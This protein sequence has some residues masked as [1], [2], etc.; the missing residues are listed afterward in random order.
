MAFWRLS[1]RES[2]TGQID[3]TENR[4]IKRWY[5]TWLP[6]LLERQQGRQ[7]GQLWDRLYLGLERL[8]GLPSDLPQE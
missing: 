7:W 1:V 2:D 3:K 5:L 8:L 6:L 4:G